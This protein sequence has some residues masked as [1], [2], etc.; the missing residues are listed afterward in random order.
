MSDI[1]K[2]KIVIESEAKGLQDIY[3]Q[4]KKISDSSNIKMNVKNQK[5]FEI[6]LSQFL[7]QFEGIKEMDVNSVEFAEF[8]KQL[9]TLQKMLE[10]MNLEMASMAINPK[11]KEQF[12]ELSNKIKKVKSDIKNTKGRIKTREGRLGDLDGLSDIEANKIVNKSLKKK[13]IVDGSNNQISTYEQVVKELERIQ[14]LSEEQRKGLSEEFNLLKNIVEACKKRAEETREAINA[15][16]ET[17]KT[18]EE[19]LANLS[20]DRQALVQE[21]NTLTDQ[22][23]YIKQTTTALEDNRIALSKQQVALDSQEEEVR[24][25][26]KQYEIYRKQQ[27]KVSNTQRATVD[28]INK[29]SES[30]QRNT[31][32]LARA[33]KQVITYGSV[34]SLLKKAY[35]VTIDTIKDMD[36]ALTDMA[37]V[38]NMSREQ[39]WQLVGEFQNLAKQTG[40]TSSEIASMATKFYQQGKSTTQVLQLTEAAAKAATIAGIS[41]SQSIDLLTNAMNGFQLSASQAMVVSDKFAALAAS[42]ATDYEELATALS[43]V[44][45]QANLAGMSMDFTLGL[46]TKGIEVTREAPETIGTALKTV[47]SRMREL[48]D[49]GATLEDGMDVNRVAKALSNIGVELM[50]EQGQFR[51][52]EEV[53][54]EVGMK[55]DT[56]NKNQQAN[57]AVAMAGTRQ[58][59][60]LIA[61]MQDFDRTLEL[62]DVSANSY[63]AT[64]AQ[65]SK[66]MGGL[67]ASTTLLTNSWQ[68]LITTLTN[69]DVFIKALDTLTGIFDAINLTVQETDALG[70]SLGILSLALVTIGVRKVAMNVAQEKANILMARANTI[71]LEHNLALREQETI[72]AEVNLAVAEARLEALKNAKATAKQEDSVIDLTEAMIDLVMIDKNAS[73]IDKLRAQKIKDKI[74]IQEAEN[75]VDIENIDNAIRAAEANVNLAKADLDMAKAT[76][77]KTQMEVA[78]AKAIEMTNGL[79][80][81]GAIAR[82]A[83]AVAEKTHTKA[84]KENTKEAVKN[85]GAWWS[86]PWFIMAGVILAVVAAI[87]AL[88]IVTITQTKKQRE[89]N[90]VLKRGCEELN[91]LQAGL[92]NLRNTKGTVSSLADE[93]TELSNKIIK[94][95]ED[96]ARMKEIINQ[97]NDLGGE[98]DENADIE[99]QMVQIAAFQVAQSF[100]EKSR[101]K[102]LQDTQ[103][104]IIKYTGMALKS[105]HSLEGLNEIFTSYFGDGYVLDP[106]GDYWKVTNS[107]WNRTKE[108]AEMSARAKYADT[109]AGSATIRTLGEYETRDLAIRTEKNKDIII[110][111]YEGI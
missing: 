92:Y 78:N 39:T 101:I 32:I 99:T 86:N 100:E 35:Q 87:S 12:D 91:K 57:V 22:E 89:A 41:G 15:E 96:L 97:I 77:I 38:T 83:L 95:N 108:T 80:V 21:N 59:S 103:D 54:T 10:K 66:Y 56:L 62:V 46:L 19:Q 33:T 67:E 44:A 28:T 16:K 61:M 49:Y 88:I 47:I 5:E 55:W 48:T 51:D 50:D 81:F 110:D 18:Q 73:E 63:G 29:A 64:M 84:T 9:G 8:Q 69:S 58:Q 4:L 27:E 37:V 93:F 85:A 24:E 79:S 105:E 31:S 45:A 94:S 23:D 60:R 75:K 3:N 74:A 98:I 34:V 68:T 30:Q 7:K 25:N 20:K 76:E 104:S 111:L 53:I 82:I 6:K 40:K 71:N 109:S 102:Q 2:K 1:I 70:V 90:E 43:K 52:L 17:L 14:G 36:K 72:Q 107:E 11:L 65:Q 42:A 13:N 26:N 106:R